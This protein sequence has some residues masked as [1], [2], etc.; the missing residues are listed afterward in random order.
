M[1][2]LREAGVAVTGELL[3]SYGTHTD[4]AA[5]ILR[6]ATDLGAGAIVLG[7]ETRGTTPTN[8]VN[9][10]IAAHAPSHVIVVNP[11]A[12][13]LG[14]PTAPAAVPLRDAPHSTHGVS[15]SGR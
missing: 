6:R 4:V 13:A 3:H 8:S 2:E 5:T 7:P 1:A 9:A 15:S 14:R 11:D 12:G 10:Y